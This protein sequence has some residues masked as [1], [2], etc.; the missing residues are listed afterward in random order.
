MEERKI[1]GWVFFFFYLM[2]FLNVN[3]LQYFILIRESDDFF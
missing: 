2:Y 3:K 1:S